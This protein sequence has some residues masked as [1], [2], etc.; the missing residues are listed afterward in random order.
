MIAGFFWEFDYVSFISK[1]HIF[2]FLKF[3][4]ILNLP[5]G[6]GRAL[7]YK[8]FRTLCFSLYF[9][10]FRQGWIRQLLWDEEILMIANISN[11]Q[12]QSHLD[13]VLQTLQILSVYGGIRCETSMQREENQIVFD[14]SKN[15]GET[16]VSVSVLTSSETRGME[17]R[18][19]KKSK[20]LRS[21]GGE[22]GLWLTSTSASRAS[23]R[24]RWGWG[25]PCRPPRPC[26]R[27]S[28]PTRESEVRIL[29]SLGTGVHSNKEN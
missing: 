13:F 8:C 5:W 29:W 4:E 24:C 28:C 19:L 1:T 26:W 20:Q 16:T 23:C 2:V 3:I 10:I 21:D 25:C 9:T 12:I 6:P 17:P 7:K 18:F 14:K 22:R 11:P 27:P 15:G